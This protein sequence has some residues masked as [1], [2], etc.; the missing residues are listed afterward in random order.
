MPLQL[1]NLDDLT[2]T[3]LVSEARRLIPTYDPGWTNHNPSDPGI[4]LLELFAY[5]SEGLL[6][7]LDRVTADNQ[8]KFLKLLNGPDWAPS[9][10]LGAD[11][12]A[13]VLAARARE[14]AVTAADYERLAIEDFNLWLAAMQRAE[15][16]GT[17]PDDWWRITQLDRAV[18]G[19]LPSNVPAVARAS[20][21][22]SRNLER[23]TEADRTAY[24]AAHVSVIVLPQDPD[25]TEPPPTQITAL[26]GYLDQWRTLT[27]R[28]HVVGPYY[29]PIS[30]E[31]VIACASGAKIDALPVRVAGQHYVGLPE[32][33]G[34]LDIFLDR[35]TGGPAQQGWPFGRDVYI[36]ELYE[37]IEAV[38][39]VDYITDLSLSSACLSTDELCVAAQPI[40]HPEGDLIGMG[41]EQ[42]ILPL[43]RFQSASIVAVPNTQFVSLRLTITL[44]AAGADAAALKRQ[45]KEMTRKFFHP[46]HD[47]P[48]P[49]TAVDTDLMLSDLKTVLG[50]ISGVTAVALDLQ[51]DTAQLLTQAG[52]IVG[53]RVPAGMIVNWQ[54]Q[55][56]VQTP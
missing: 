11:I 54:T 16:S 38:D 55:V 15:Q 29:A 12:R 39:G 21:V 2:Y 4:T 49:T 52:Q 26:W 24:A 36:S 30:A 6:Y 5:L 41:L 56:L 32:I 53:L 42:H 48:S 13:T 8:R 47:G 10:D 31:I 9:T 27:T 18:P 46:L 33:D 17:A 3:D 40:W 35:L 44:T 25:M 43:A 19:N 50:T 22:P 1:P 20:C 14:R 45:A 28:H 23:G 34:Q 37:Q 51:A 7:R